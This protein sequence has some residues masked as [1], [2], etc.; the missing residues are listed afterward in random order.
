MDKFRLFIAIEIPSK[1][2]EEISSIVTVLKEYNLDIK[3][4]SID[5]HHLTLVFLGE[6]PENKIPQLKKI[7]DEVA[8]NNFEITAEINDKL[9]YFHRIRKPGVLWIGFKK[10]KEELISISSQI[11]KLLLKNN[12]TLSDKEYTPHLTLGR[13]K[14]SKNV[15]LLKEKINAKQFKGR[16][17]KL[18]KITL[19]KSEL[20]S[21]GPT[22]IKLYEA[23]L[24]TL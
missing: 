24:K 13:F 19:Y 23:K 22:H 4:T 7:I 20:S 3:W 14:S 12:Y 5:N 9:D 2:K 17:F 16:E 18:K 21:T 11:T 6:I 8:G 10:G 15:R 1:I